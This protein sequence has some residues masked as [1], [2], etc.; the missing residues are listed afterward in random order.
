VQEFFWIACLAILLTSILSA[1]VPAMGAFSEY[2]LPGQANWLHD[3]DTLRRG[4]NLYFVL[5][6]MVGIVSFP[7]FHTV[8]AVLAI[9]ITRGTGAVGSL[10][11]IWNVIMLFSIAPIGGHYF[12]D[13]IGGGVVLAVSVGL[14]RSSARLRQKRR[15]QF[16]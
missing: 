16:G 4:S 5:P 1:V 11:T 8:L 7:S 3:L 12:V 14:V 15:A 9:Y 10:F 13:M 6:D 2:G